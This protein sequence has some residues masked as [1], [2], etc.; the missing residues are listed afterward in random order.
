MESKSVALDATSDMYE[1]RALPFWAL[2]GLFLT[3][4]SEVE[5][6]GE[7]G[8]EADESESSRTSEVTFNASAC[9]RRDL[10]VF[11]PVDDSAGT[12]SSSSFLF[13]KILAAN[14][15]RFF[16]AFTGAMIGVKGDDTRSDSLF[17]A[18]KAVWWELFF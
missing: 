5:G 10:R 17:A 13:W 8:G 1:R 2:R 3:A 14:L 9:F 15:P 6:G 4:G 7:G 12:C 16:L 18:V 11:I